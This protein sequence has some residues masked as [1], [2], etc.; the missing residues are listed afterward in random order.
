[1]KVKIISKFQRKKNVLSAISQ[2]KSWIKKELNKKL[3][4][5]PDQEKI[6]RWKDQ[7]QNLETELKKLN[8]YLDI[9]KKE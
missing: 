5:I 4:K 8:A 9:S 2:R 6:A 3:P 7:Q 1:M